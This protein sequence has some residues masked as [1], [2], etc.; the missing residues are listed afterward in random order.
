MVTKAVVFSSRH[1]PPHTA[2]RGGVGVAFR[3]GLDAQGLWLFSIL[4]K[5]ATDC[6]EKRSQVLR[7]KDM[8]ENYVMPRIAT[9]LEDWD[10]YSNEREYSET[11]FQLAEDTPEEKPLSTEAEGISY[12]SVA[13]CRALCES[14][15]DCVQYNYS[16]GNCRVSSTIKLGQQ[17]ETKS[18][19]MR[20]GWLIDRVVSFARNMEPCETEDWILS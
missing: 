17:T 8:F 3:A 2:C 13:N 6:C 14:Q 9:E 16:P 7:H 19:G 10:N 4:S 18:A 11:P 20:S 15:S 1:I 12:K 5:Y